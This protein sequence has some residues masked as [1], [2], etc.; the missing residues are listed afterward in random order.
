VRQV[1]ETLDPSLHTTRGPVQAEHPDARRYVVGMET[2]GGTPAG[3]VRPPP[4]SD[5]GHYVNLAGL[6]RTGVMQVP[7]DGHFPA[8]VD[9]VNHAGG[10]YDH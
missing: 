10:P 9:G 6:G 5:N 1:T 7:I 4:G 3:L 2:R 8:R